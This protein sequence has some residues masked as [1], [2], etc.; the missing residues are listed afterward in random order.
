LFE[1][2]TLSKILCT[3]HFTMVVGGHAGRH[4]IHCAYFLDAKLIQPL[5][6]RAP[7]YLPYHLFLSLWSATAANTNKQVWVVSGLLRHCDCQHNVHFG[8]P[9]AT[10]FI[11]KGNH[12][13]QW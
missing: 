3:D 1:G 10:L 4:Q 5:S 9:Y 6:V 13:G 8:K 12:E 11:T 2:F 7:P